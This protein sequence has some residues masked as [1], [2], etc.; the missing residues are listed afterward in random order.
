MSVLVDTDITIDFL[1]GHDHA[2]AHLKTVAGD[3]CFSA[4]TVAE[5]YTGIRS[6]QEEAEV[7]R[8]FAV[9]PVIPVTRD[10][11]REAGRLVNTFGASHSVE[12]PDALIAATCQAFGA[13]LH[14]LNTRHYPMLS[15][16]ER[17]YQKKQR[18][19]DD[20]TR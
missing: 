1:R 17:P 15:G 2:V 5:I 13:A 16:L 4:V 11:A 19:G 10:I 3:L 12:L 14:T 9:F 8:L 18:K 20:V 7:E 6:R